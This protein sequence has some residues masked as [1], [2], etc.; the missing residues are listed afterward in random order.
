M[1]ISDTIEPISDSRFSILQQKVGVDSSTEYSQNVIEVATSGGSSPT[2]INVGQGISE[3]NMSAQS[4]TKINLRACALQ[5]KFQFSNAANNGNVGG[6]SMM[7]WNTAYVIDTMTLKING[8]SAV[9]FHAQNAGLYYH[10]FFGRLISNYSGAALEELHNTLFTPIFNNVY[11]DS[12]GGVIPAAPQ[13]YA[14]RRDRCRMGTFTNTCVKII[15]FSDLFPIAKIDA[16]ST[17]IMS[18][19]LHITWRD[20][21]NILSYFGAVGTDRCKII[22]AKIINDMCVL[23]SSQSS[24][25]VDKKMNGL[26]ENIPFIQTES[27]TL[28]FVANTQITVP[29]IANLDR[30]MLLCPCKGVGTYCMPDEYLPFSTSQVATA[31][32]SVNPISS[33][34]MRYGNISYPALAI[35]T[36]VS[37]NAVNHFS[38]NQLYYHYMKAI[39]KDESYALAPAVSELNFERTMPFVMLRPF[40]SMSPKI[41]PRGY[42]IQLILNGGTSG[43]GLTNIICILFRL[44]IM[45]LSADGSAQLIL[46]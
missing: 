17:S 26:F 32:L 24:Q 27:R 7:P 11:G 14:E 33:I 12:A 28:P 9:A 15:K 35:E 6:I 20:S 45:Q 8:S 2:G 30:L 39:H 34:Q 19:S 18:L 38:P 46:P 22:E 23:S 3:F 44:S 10:D 42:D 5:L 36:S 43:V 29:N 4:G 21:Q 31:R 1:S 13:I 41:N 16:I 37:E 40:S 25:I